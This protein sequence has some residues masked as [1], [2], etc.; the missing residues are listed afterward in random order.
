MGGA[1]SKHWRDE[2]AYNIFVGRPEGKRP[3]ERPWCRWEDNIRMDLTEIG[4]EGVDCVHLAKDRHQWRAVVN[5]VMNLR[6]LQKAGNLTSFS[7][8]TLFH[9]SV[10]NNV[11]DKRPAV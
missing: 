11:A 8:R 9:E 10:T 1:C 6:V 5:T 7:R 2:N 3:L 4:W